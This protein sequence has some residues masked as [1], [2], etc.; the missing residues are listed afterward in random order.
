MNPRRTKISRHSHVNR[1]EHAQD[2]DGPFSPRRPVLRVFDIIGGE[3]DEAVRIEMRGC[4][5]KVFRSVRLVDCVGQDAS[6]GRRHHA[7]Q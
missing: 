5:A 1:Q 3:S 6:D 7:Y 2:C 4:I